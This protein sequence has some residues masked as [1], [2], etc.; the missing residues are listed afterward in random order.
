[1]KTK[2]KT[3]TKA[4]TPSPLPPP[5]AN[6]V[7]PP[8]P[9]VAQVVREDA[10]VVYTL[11][12]A[13]AKTRAPFWQRSDA[14]NVGF[15]L[16]AII[17]VSGVVVAI[18]LFGG[19]EKRTPTSE[20][21]PPDV[22]KKI[23]DFLP[24]YDALVATAV[25]IFVLSIVSLLLATFSAGFAFLDVVFSSGMVLSGILFIAIGAMGVSYY[26]QGLPAYQKL[27]SIAGRDNPVPIDAFYA[28]IAFGALF[29]IVGLLLADYSSVG[30]AWYGGGILGRARYAYDEWMIGPKILIG[31]EGETGAGVDDVRRR[32]VAR[33]SKAGVFARIRNLELAGKWGN[34]AA[35]K[36][37]E[38]GLATMTQQGR[39]MK[40]LGTK[41]YE[42][43]VVKSYT[44]LQNADLTVKEERAAFE[45]KNL[46]VLR[47]E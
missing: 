43:G 20:D 13:K 37:R 14:R 1:M 24:A 8:A 30:R 3:K 4:H 47:A 28:S 32:A 33:G 27:A 21:V 45:L 7:A 42:A 25:V 44:E 39:Y 41:L 12:R 40:T 17:A 22:A 9:K 6:V 38:R 36:A 19:Q 23:A 5:V 26:E 46:G 35:V 34:R 31:D 2:T 11:D 15:L 10:A 18:T 16:A 29:V